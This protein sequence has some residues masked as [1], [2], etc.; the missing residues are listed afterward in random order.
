MDEDVAAGEGTGDYEEEDDEDVALVL[1]DEGTVADDI[2]GA[3]D[4][5]ADVLG[6]GAVDPQQQSN[7]D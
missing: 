6:A 5:N 4:I 2:V 7:R 3:E 1:E